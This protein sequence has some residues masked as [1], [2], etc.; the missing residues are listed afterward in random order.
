MLVLTRNPDESIMI[1][2]NIEVALE[3]VHGGV[4]ELTFY[5]PAGI[6][7]LKK[8]ATNMN[9]TPSFSSVASPPGDELSITLLEGQSIMI[10]DQIE[11]KLCLLTKGQAR[12]GIQAPT[13]IK[14]Y[15]FEIYEDI[16][17][18]AAKETVP[19]SLIPAQIPSAP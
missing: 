11:V 18:P 6:S 15:R 17:S 4:A 19:S 9:L 10:G 5:V 12:I 7:V 2:D 8:T 1:G 13:N 14:V 3:S 16:H